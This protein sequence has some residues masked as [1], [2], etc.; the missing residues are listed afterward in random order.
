VEV[1]DERLAVALDQ[2][3]MAFADGGTG[4]PQVA[5]RVPADEELRVREVE[6]LPFRLARGEDHK[7]E[8]HKKRPRC[9]VGEG[10]PV[11]PPVLRREGTHS[12][13]AEGRGRRRRPRLRVP[14]DSGR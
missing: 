10:L 2:R 9:P 14:E 5:L 8:L 12:V 11:F 7:T 13:A 3:T 1:A 6:D 4:R